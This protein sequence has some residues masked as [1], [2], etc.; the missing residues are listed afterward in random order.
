[1]LSVQEAVRLKRMTMT[2]NRDCSIGGGIMGLNGSRGND[3]M[4]N[5]ARTAN[6]EAHHLEQEA[7]DRKSPGKRIRAYIVMAA[8]VLFLVTMVMLMFLAA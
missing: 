8:M 3:P 5:V 2:V 7:A 4:W 6:L 1:M